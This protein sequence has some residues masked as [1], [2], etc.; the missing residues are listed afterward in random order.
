[1]L[2][3]I[4]S[5][6]ASPGATTTA[7]ALA[8]MWPAAGAG[9]P[10]LLEADPAGG[11]IA[12][13][14]SLAPA[15]G[16]VSLSAAARHEHGADLLY[17]HA[18]QLPGGLPVLAAPPA[19]EAARGAVTLLARDGLPLLRAAAAQPDLALVAD[20][21]RLQADSPAW[22]VAEAADVLLLVVRPV[23][24]ELTRVISACE[25]LGARLAAAGTRLAL[26]TVGRG[27]FPTEEIAT[28]TGIAVAAAL[29]D[30]G[31]AA[32]MLTGRPDPRGTLS[33]LSG[34]G[35]VAALPLARAAA[36]LAARLAADVHRDEEA[37]ESADAIETQNAAAPEP[38][39]AR[40]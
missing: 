9:Q 15:P 14:F 34:R 18:L 36:D 24:P 29:P 31:A 22:P 32:A 39:G 26:V 35:Q 38:M 17:E 27:P 6:K 16:L 23:L 12:A 13:R 28:A 5:L 30:D 1:M 21:G 2:I 40:T 4:G 33:R 3:A 7:Q 25:Q 20:V 8:A 10:L 11:D 37:D 19:E